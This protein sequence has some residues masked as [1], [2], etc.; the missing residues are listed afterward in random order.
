MRAEGG[1]DVAGLSDVARS[2]EGAGM[3]VLGC[4]GEK[5]GWGI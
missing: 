5:E 4:V 1:W 2:D 3:D